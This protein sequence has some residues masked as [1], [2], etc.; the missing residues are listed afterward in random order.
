M[1][2]LTMAASDFRTDLSSPT[3]FSYFLLLIDD[4]CAQRRGSDQVRPWNRLGSSGQR[5]EARP[6]DCDRA[7]MRFSQLTIQR[8]MRVRFDPR[9]GKFVVSALAWS[10]IP[11]AYVVTDACGVLDQKNMWRS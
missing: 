10:P 9:S 4:L 8:P 11:G 1:L 6:I 3:V 5:G 7:C 2:V